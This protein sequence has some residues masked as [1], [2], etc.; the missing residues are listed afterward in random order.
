M[1]VWF[2]CVVGVCMCECV[3]GFLFVIFL[4]DSFSKFYL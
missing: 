2:L 1:L 3:C 4:G